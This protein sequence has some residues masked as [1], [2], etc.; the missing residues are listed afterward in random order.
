VRTM[1]KRVV[2]LNEAQLRAVISEMMGAPPDDD[3]H[4]LDDALAAVK[5]SVQGLQGAVAAGPHG[6]SQAELP[7][8]AQRSA[9]T[10]EQLLAVI[11]RIA[12]GGGRAGA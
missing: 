1:R 10:V 7:Q 8:I 3:W 2:R 12:A 11:N 4:R 5:R 6:P 9:R